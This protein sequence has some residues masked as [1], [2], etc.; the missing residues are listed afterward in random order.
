MNPAYG[1]NHSSLPHLFLTISFK[2]HPRSISRGAMRKETIAAVIAILVVASLGIGYLS[3]NDTRATETMTSVSTS[4]ITSTITSTSIE[5]SVLTQGI[6]VPVSSAS[7]LNSTTGLSLNLNLSTNSNDW[8]IVTVYEFNTL[9]QATNVS[10]ADSWP[11][12][13]SL[14]QWVQSYNDC[15]GMAGY[16]LLQGNYGL[17][18]FSQGTALWLQP[19][20][21]LLGCCVEVEPPTSYA[22]KPLSEA[23]VLYGSYPGFFAGGSAYTPFAP[24]V[25]TVLAGDEWGDVAILHF[26]VA[27]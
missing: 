12:N 6:L 3:G 4:T 22:F 15:C 8:V 11:S 14:F 5:T 18:N 7:T 26:T 17:N 13:T 24:G 1:V 25:Y 10:V 2:G 23:D 19:K 21:S 16:E 20:P 27:G 9:D